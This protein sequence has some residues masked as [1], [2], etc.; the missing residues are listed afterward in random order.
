MVLLTSGLSPFRHLGRVLTVIVAP[1]FNSVSLIMKKL[2]ISWE[3]LQNACLCVCT[4]L[5]ATYLTSGQTSDGGH[6][7]TECKHSSCSW[8]NL[9]KHAL[10]SITHL[11]QAT[12]F[13]IVHGTAVQLLADEDDHFHAPSYLR[14]SVNVSTILL[15]SSYGCRQSGSRCRR[16]VV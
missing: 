9:C 12:G 13:G 1:S 11:Q 10:T 16:T 8:D 15:A 4:C 5:F 14:T 2:L 7:V 6:N 3:F